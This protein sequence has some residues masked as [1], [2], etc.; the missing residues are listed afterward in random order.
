[1]SAPDHSAAADFT[2]VAIDD[3]GVK[4]EYVKSDPRLQLAHG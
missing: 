3:R 1:M 2:Y 4:R